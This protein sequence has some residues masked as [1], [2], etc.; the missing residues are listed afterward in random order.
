MKKN[1]K[2]AYLAAL[3]YA[4]IAGLSFLFTKI[5]VNAASP[6][7]V[8]AYRLLGPFIVLSISILLKQVRVDYTKRRVLRLLP[9]SL[10]Y[11]LSFFGFQA[12]GL[13]YASSAEA[14]I[15]QASVP[16]FVA[17]LAFYILKEKI[18]IYQRAGILMS[19]FGVV[20]ILA[21]KG[22]ALDFVD[23]RGIILL[24]IAAFSFAV[25]NVFAR[26]AL[27]DFTN[28]ELSYVLI[29]VS[30]VFFG[31]LSL[32]GHKGDWRALL[33]PLREPLFLIAV[34]YLGL[35]CTLATSLL[36]NYVLSKME[37]SKLSVFVNLSTVISIFAGVAVLDEK[38]SYYH[39]IGTALIIGGVFTTNFLDDEGLRALK[40]RIAAASLE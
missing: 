27:L 35:L 9:L 20:Y 18:N 13:K 32:L 16:V 25:Y 24:I 7:D 34:L 30:F 29:S 14:G 23:A 22:I 39:F 28:T 36:V 37:A 19:V 2:W 12:F 21:K 33:A 10:L 8:L 3:L 31:T 26:R 11:P 5:A 17:I 40:E 4:V 15:V 1:L 38:I 6:L